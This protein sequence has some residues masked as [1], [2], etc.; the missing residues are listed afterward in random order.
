MSPR[1]FGET[2]TQGNYEEALLLKLVE[3]DLK[4]GTELGQCQMWKTIWEEEEKDLRARYFPGPAVNAANWPE[5]SQGQGMEGHC[6]YPFSNSS[7]RL[8]NNLTY[9]AFLKFNEE[10]C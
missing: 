6:C 2:E 4:V 1:N 9:S 8:S 10:R 3:Q 5:A 7:T